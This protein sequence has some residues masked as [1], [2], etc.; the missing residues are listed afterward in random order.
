MQPQ[1]S[2]RI[3]NVI[4]YPIKGCKGVQRYSIPISD[5]GFAID[6]I[7]AIL[8]SKSELPDT[9][10]A[11]SQSKFPKLACVVP[12]DVTDDSISIRA[13]G[14]PQLFH[15]TV[16][17][18]KMLK[19]DLWGDTVEAIDQGDPASE[20]FSDY[21]G[22]PVRFAR[23]SP[24]NKRR[25]PL[26]NPQTTSLFYRTPILLMSK[27]SVAELS[28]RVNENLS[29][30]RF[31]PNIVLSGLDAFEEDTIRELQ[32]GDVSLEISELCERC[33]IPSV[34]PIL[35]KLQ[36]KLLAKMREM[37]S[38]SKVMKSAAPKG[39]IHEDQ[40]Y[41]GV[42]FLPKVSVPLSR[43]FVGQKVCVV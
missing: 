12:S 37:R 23:I 6:R 17:D 3:E 38:G 13:P 1:K 41:L 43:I 42:Y 28:V 33:S 36:T 11:V 16:F 34:D 9:W 21:L 5:K 14:M 31:R 25:D 30:E 4:F 20:W 22:T 29:F 2:L 27:E 10:T 7:Y 26:G 32:I 18:G 39:E 35:G 8:Q 40:Y 15:Q 19:I 24:G